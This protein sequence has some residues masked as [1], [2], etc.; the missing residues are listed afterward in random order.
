M[1]KLKEYGFEVFT[2]TEVTFGL[3]TDCYRFTMISR[4]SPKWNLVGPWLIQGADFLSC[5]NANAV[6]FDVGI[7]AQATSLF[8]DV[9]CIKLFPI[10]LDDL[11]ICTV[12]LNNFKSHA[13]TITEYNI[14]SNQCFVLPSLMEAYIYSVSHQIPSSYE[15]SSYDMF[16][17]HWKKK[18]GI[19]IPEKPGLFYQVYFTSNPENILT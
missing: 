7:S 16:R 3:V 8:L 10:Q 14:C 6:K 12:V 11:G 18:H 1:Q 17:L 13:T 15:L 9:Q 5:V 2:K 19:I 4:L